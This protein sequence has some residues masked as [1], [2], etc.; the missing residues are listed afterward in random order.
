MEGMTVDLPG[1]L[2]LKEKYKFDLFV[3]EAH[4]IGAIG[5]HGHG[6]CDY[7]GVDP[8]T[9]DVLMGTLTKSFGASGGYIAGS[10]TL[11][12]RLRV[13]SYSGAYAESISPPV[14]T[15]IIASMVSITSIDTGG[16]IVNS[17]THK[18][19]LHSSA[20]SSFSTIQLEIQYHHPGPVPQRYLPQ[21]ISLP[22]PCPLVPKA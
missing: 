8:R 11:I 21:W 19:G 17:N 7:F 5:P 15:Q 12:D 22:L 18:S 10:R 4:S 14:F 2:E 6:V 9:I 3:D 16:T 1:L 13:C 20:S